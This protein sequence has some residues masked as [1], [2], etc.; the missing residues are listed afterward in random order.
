MISIVVPVY[1][2]EKYIVETIDMVRK[3]T[4]TDWELIL[5][6]DCSKDGSAAVIREHM[7]TLAKTQGENRIKFIDKTVNAGAAA[8]RN[9]GVDAATGRYIAF[10][11]ADDIWYPHKLE[12]EML[13]MEHHK[14]GFVFTGY[15]YGDENAVPTGKSCRVPK[16]LTYRQALSRTVIF[17][18]TVLFDTEIVDKKL[19]HMPNV[20]SEDSA[21]WWQILKT[22]ITAYGLNQSLAI[23]RRPK[24]S[25]SSDKKVAIKR[26]WNL[27]VN[28][29]K[30]SIPLAALYMFEWAFRAT[31]RR[32][33]SD[34]ITGHLEAIRR[35]TA[36]ELMLLGIV[37]QTGMY[38]WFWF[39]KYYPIISADR[40]SK[41]GY[42]FGYGLKLYFRGHLLVLAIYFVILLF[43]TKQAGGLR[44]GHLRIKSLL[45]AQTFGIITTNVIT[46]L[47]LSLLRNWLV[48]KRPMLYLSV[49]QIVFSL[50]WIVFADRIY[51]KVFPAREM[52]AI[53]LD[54]KMDTVIDCFAIHPDRYKIGNVISANLPMEE[55]KDHCL[56]WYGAVLLGAM[57]KERQDE[58]AEF[59]YGHHIRVYFVPD[60]YDC[61]KNSAELIERMDSPIMEIK[62]YSISW[63]KRI[64]KR[65]FDILSSLLLLIVTSPI[66]AVILLFEKKN[67]NPAVEKINCMGKGG[68]E[69]MRYRFSDNGKRSVYICN[70]PTLI[71][72]LKGD[73]SFVG[74][75]AYK[76]EYMHERIAA[77]QRY[78]YRLRVQ[79]GLVGVAQKNRKAVLSD[80]DQLIYD[81]YYILHFSLGM[82]VRLILMAIRVA[83]N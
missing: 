15:D 27:Y 63:E 55:L 50:F 11:D 22:G 21:T 44:S 61:V 79:P 64:I 2:A 52:L 77:D 40:V 1:N 24:K 9:T 83:E 31:Y 32:V 58:L 13:F 33:I 4:Y 71:N 17:T 51:R 5:V 23:Y 62:E 34:N 47:Q 57:P 14:A 56:R 30:L 39:N 6:N 74:P 48:P 65:V 67:G 59:C 8:A 20:G 70:I 60:V 29:E 35:F 19:I 16:T 54:G 73:M 43:L 18:S 78:F 26:I 66:S 68:K 36:F 10:L 80:E 69:F 41:D 12:K 72:V 76:A 53:G 49:M 82:D 7:E 75:R 45:T 38:A 37:I 3:Q 28:V 25:L 46:F 42:Y 81:L